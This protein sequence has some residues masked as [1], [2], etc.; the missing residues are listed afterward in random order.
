[1]PVL[2][3]LG[4]QQAEYE[5]PLASLTGT[6]SQCIFVGCRDGEVVPE[7]KSQEHP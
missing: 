4:E 6:G 7:K 1:M 2:S 5:L 3:G